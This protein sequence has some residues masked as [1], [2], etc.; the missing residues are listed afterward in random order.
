MQL[1]FCQ[2]HTTAVTKLRNFRGYFVF[3]VL[4]IGNQY[5]VM[6]VTKILLAKH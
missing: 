5:I 4:T 1:N 6:F 2:R 3:N